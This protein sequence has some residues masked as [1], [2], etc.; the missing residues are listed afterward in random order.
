MSVRFNK[1]RPTLEECTM[2]H[3]PDTEKIGQNGVKRSTLSR[4]ESFKAASWLTANWDKLKTM[5]RAQAAEELSK[6]TSKQVTKLA[7]RGLLDDMERKWPG[8]DTP[9]VDR[10]TGNPRYQYGRKLAV[11]LK[12]V[13]A[14]FDWFGQQH[15]IE[16]PIRLD[17]VLLTEI[18]GGRE[19][20][21]DNGPEDSDD[22]E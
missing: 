16:C 3:A 9:R 1:F 17:M 2:S 22:D 15:G 5:T 8:L 12:K 19:A 6:L 7:L 20:R 21:D 14:M 11:Q 18:A 13:Q 10:V 4:Q